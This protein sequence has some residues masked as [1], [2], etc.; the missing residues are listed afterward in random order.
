MAMMV[1]ALKGTAATPIH[2][3]ENEINISVVQT[4]IGLHPTEKPMVIS[5]NEISG[6]WSSI[7]GY[8][9]NQ[10]QSEE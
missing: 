3:R 5:I 10:L 9:E 6:N 1:E 7:D 8:E 4:E 2:H